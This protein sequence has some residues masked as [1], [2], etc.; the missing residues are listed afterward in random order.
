MDEYEAM[1]Y[2]QFRRESFQDNERKGT[3]GMTLGFSVVA[4]LLL[5]GVFNLYY[6]RKY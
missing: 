4:L 5:F 6:I 3:I 1:E 2:C